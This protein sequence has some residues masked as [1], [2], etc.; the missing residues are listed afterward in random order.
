M[1]EWNW[2]RRRQSKPMWRC[3]EPGFPLKILAQISAALL[4]CGAIECRAALEIRVPLLLDLPSG[5]AGSWPVACGVPFTAGSLSDA[6]SLG[7]VD[8]AGVAAP[9]QA[10]VTAT[11]LD[12]S[13]RWIMLHFIA[14]PGK[15]YFAVTGQD[16]SDRADA[17]DGITMEESDAGITIKTGG[18]KYYIAAD[19]ALIAWADFNGRPLLRDSGRGAYLK[20]QRGRIGRLG[21]PRSEM[22][23]SFR[24][25]GP[26]WT[27]LRKEGWYVTDA[28]ERIARGI[29]WLDFFGGCPFVKLTHRLVLTE[30]TNEAWFKDI[31]LDFNAAP[32]AAAAALFPLAR[33]ADRPPLEVPLNPGESA[34]ML[35]DDFPHFMQTNSHYAVARAVRGGAAAELAAGPACGDWCAWQGAAGGYAVVLRDFAEQFPK[36][37]YAT[38]AGLTVR[39]WAERA[40][41]EL[42]FR[43]PSLI[44]D[45]WGE[46]WSSKSDLGLDVLKKIPSN[47]QGAAKTHVLW[48]LPHAGNPP[49]DAIAARA[50]MAARGVCAMSDPA[51]ICGAGVMGLDLHPKDEA[52]YTREELYIS[53]FFDRHLLPHRVFPMTGWIAWGANM[54]TRYGRESD[55]GKYYMTWWRMSGL[56]DY[57][58]RNSVWLLYARSG[59]RKY[60]EYATRFNRFAGDM[61]M[62]HW[63]CGDEASGTRKV[64]GGFGGAGLP[65]GAEAA[66]MGEAGSAGSLPIY[67]RW[68]SCKAGWAG[69]SGADVMN[70]LHHF[71]FTGDWD[72]RELVEACAEATIKHEFMQTAGVSWGGNFLDLR[73]LAAMYSMDWN[74][75][76][77]AMVR[78]LAGQNMDLNS[79]NGVSEKMTPTPTYKA[80]RVAI[81]MLAVYGLTR[82]L[83]VLDC[84]LKMVDYQY[85]FQL[86]ERPVA[87]QSASGMY[88][89]EAAL[90]T[91]DPRYL[92][93]AWQS[94]DNALSEFRAPLAEELEDAGGLDQLTGLPWYPAHYNYFPFVSLPVLMQARAKFPGPLEP[95][96]LLRKHGASTANAWAA[97][98]KTAGRTATLDMHFILEESDEVQP[99]VYGPDGRLCGDFQVTARERRFDSSVSGASASHWLR[100]VLPAAWP[101]GVYRVGHA[102]RGPFTVLDA[103][104]ARMVLDCP[105]GFWLSMSGIEAP[106]AFYFHVP[107]D[108]RAVKLFISRPVEI[109]RGDGSPAEIGAGGGGTPER[110]P[111]GYIT[112]SVPPGSAGDWKITNREPA[113][114]RLLNL[115]PFVSYLVPGRLFAPPTLSGPST[116][117]ADATA[118]PAPAEQYVPG[119]I[120]GGLQL[121]GGRTLKFKRGAPLPDG[122]YENFPGLAGTIEFWFRPNWT[123]LDQAFVKLQRREWSLVSAG[124]IAIYYVYGQKSA[125]AGMPDAFLAFACGKS[126]FASRGRYR[127]FGNAAGLFPRAGEWMHIAVTWEF[128][129]ARQYPVF[130]NHSLIY[131]NGRLRRR[132]VGGGDMLRSNTLEDFDLAGIPEWITLGGD[133]AF[134]ELRVSSCVRYAD[135]FDPPRA[136]F[137]PD[138]ATKLLM[139]FDGPIPAGETSAWKLSP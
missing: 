8:D 99:V 121:A 80:S 82:D 11:W 70:Y 48:F 71:Y 56:T 3:D 133:G 112:L 29:V 117:N 45:Y 24:V 14:T 23:T 41:R 102:D 84:F 87:Y 69:G 16:L 72:V 103:D 114:V 49:D 128:D 47:A 34:W 137:T 15:K 104:V 124:N 90:F 129:P 21:G 43:V 101:A 27:V 10:D 93:I 44:R 91:G 51:W 135:D 119:V 55:T 20:D 139:R 125:I 17:A 7:V 106:G 9:A 53:D 74:P 111:V 100:L 97:L 109:T 13:V 60:L 25:R 86:S 32:A 2:R 33:G 52:G 40:G 61:N 79:P 36:E 4:A 73:C 107:E 96:P 92:R 68:H 66:K 115:P 130:Y 5:P 75:E 110:E 39:L 94:V 138:A 64:R 85:R 6:G 63:D 19:G 30:D 26:H 65:P 77:G 98:E 62:H 59:E 131:V 81:S 136:P 50:D 54:G 67:W 134:D 37:F 57:H 105:E 1:A 83:R 58:M 18:A 42:D 123:A 31:G 28:G 78:N 127:Q 95:L 88:N 120:G 113:F 122:S 108:C 89:A 132:Q 76:L 126:K 46:D 116:P 35:Q 22:Q 38:T 118:L 12:G